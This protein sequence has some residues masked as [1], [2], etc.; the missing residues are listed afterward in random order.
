M[1]CG[2]S[3]NAGDE[4]ELARP[5][6]GSTTQQASTAPTQQVPAQQSATTEKAASNPDNPVVYFDVAI[7]GSLSIPI[8]LS[9]SSSSCSPRV[10]LTHTTGKD[11]GRIQ[12]ELFLD[13]VPATAENF[14][15]LCTGEFQGG[16]YKGSSFHRVVS[17]LTSISRFP[18]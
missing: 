15:R 5:A 6:Q 12:M 7:G 17:N 1:G 16:G 9:I 4:T 11:A 13:V 10:S 3:K 14:R 8:R 2:S 18:T